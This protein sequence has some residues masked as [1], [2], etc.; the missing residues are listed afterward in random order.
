MTGPLPTL[1]LIAIT[2]STSCARGVS[3]TALDNEPASASGEPTQ[4]PAPETTPAPP[5][6]VIPCP[7][8][9]RLEDA[10]PF[11]A[12]ELGDLPKDLS[13]AAARI[14]GAHCLIRIDEG[15]RALDLVTG[16]L[17]LP[18]SSPLHSYARLVGGEA[19]LRADDV[20]SA[21]THLAGLEFPEGPAARR[22]QNLRGEALVRGG[23]N[24]PGK[25]QLEAFL[26]G[27]WGSYLL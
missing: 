18:S 21:L 10:G 6:P 17:A 12:D 27:A 8:A 23:K 7:N 14:A 3:P 19:A 2:L 11:S 1:I 25:L 16:L 15:R 22:L 26:K 13:L 20:T 9:E 4:S 24:A 5:P